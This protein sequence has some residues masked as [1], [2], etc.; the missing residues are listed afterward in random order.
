MSDLQISVCDAVLQVRIARPERHNALSRAT[1][2][3]IRA[4]F[5]AHADDPGLKAAVLTGTGEASFAAGGDLR[6]L[7]VVRE[8]DEAEVMVRD[9]H[10]ALTAVREFPLPVIAALNGRAIGGGAELA[11]SCDFRIA[12]AQASLG[13]VHGKL[14]ISSQWGGGTALVDLLGPHKALYAMASGTVFGA[15]A[16]LELGL[17]DVVCEP[18]ETL[19]DAVQAFLA[20][21]LA[22]APQVLRA[23]KSHVLAAQRGLPAVE[24]VAMELVSAVDT[25]LHPDH[26]TAADRVLKPRPS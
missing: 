8:R 13:Y 26:W 24:R 2:A 19:E 23:A 21:M 9:A 11:T 4:A 20:P 10:A 1:L 6:D 22:M 16:A 17:V 15:R 18:G 5:A 3:E 25:W 12:T 14:G 7:A